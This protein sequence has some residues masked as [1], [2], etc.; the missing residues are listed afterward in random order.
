MK[1]P[2]PPETPDPYKTAAA[3]QMANVEVA[4]A[5]TWLMNA[6]EDNPQGT[7]R[8]QTTGDTIATHT[9]DANGNIT[10]TRYVP[11]FKKTVALTPEGQTQYDQQIDLAIAM[12]EWALAQTGHLRSLQSTPFAT[13]SLTQHTSPPDAAAIDTSAV[14][15]RP[16]IQS[17]GE[18]DL[19]AHIEAVRDALDDRV[20]YQIALDRAARITALANQG[21]VPGM[22][23][24]DRDLLAFDRASTDARLRAL[25]EARAE[26]TR[27]IQTE[28][29]VAGHHNQTVET[30]FKLGAA[31]VDIRNAR[32]TQQ[33]QALA[34]ASLF[35]A[36]R[37]QQ[38]FQEA[39]AVRGQ[40]INEL[41]ALMHGGQIQIPQFQAFRAGN[42]DRTPVADSVYQSA[43]MDMQKWQARV[44]AQ[45]QMMGGI[46]GFAGNMMG[47]MFALSDRRLKRDVR[48][49]WRDARGVGWYVWRYLWDSA[50]TRRLGVMA[51]EVPW[52]AVA[53]PSGF[54]AV[55]YRRM[56]L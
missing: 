18:A 19:V 53:L 3:Q 23:A 10:G 55:D 1:A 45:S 2:K 35:V 15:H 7:V 30:E 29:I 13:W 14:S 36:T 39:I 33:Y 17:I 24:Y 34:D 37:R 26:Q 9:Y 52:A 25:L 46:L 12:N 47:G 48:L 41:S 27:M 28:A 38:Q 6:D 31:V 40:N 4:L 11:K 51:Q 8:F 49:L 54:L 5:N 50:G 42:I 32:R 43:A 21:L 22:T 16:L 56:L 20:Q 44:Q